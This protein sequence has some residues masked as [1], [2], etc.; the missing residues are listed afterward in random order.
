MKSSLRPVLTFAVIAFA[1]MISNT[2][3]AE[4]LKVKLRPAQITNLKADLQV[5]LVKVLPKS[6]G[7]GEMVTFVGNVWNHDQGAAKNPAV[8]ITVV[9]PPGVSIPVYRKEFNATFN[10]GQGFTVTYKFKVPKPGAYTC[11]L[12]VDQA[13]EIP[14]SDNKNNA[15]D[16]SFGV[17]SLCDLIVCISNGKRPPVGRKRAIDAV[18]YNI[19]NSSSKFSEEIKLSFYVEGHGVKAFT[20]PSLPKGG[21]HKVRRNHKWPTSGTKTITANI[22]YTGKEINKNNNMVSGSYFVR[23]PHHNDYGGG[24]PVKCSTN[25]D[26]SNWEQCDSQY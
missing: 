11:A 17:R 9:G 22:S 21:S 15:K 12:I 16:I 24:Q 3:W 23:L 2:L 4:P 13:N 20:I 5:D 14:E 19:G 8:L 10:K 6:I 18:V 26:F 1:F 7:E 25:S